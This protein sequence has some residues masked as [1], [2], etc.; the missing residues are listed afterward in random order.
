[1]PNSSDFRELRKRLNEIRKHFLPKKFSPTGAYTKREYDK[2]RGYCLLVHAEIEAYLEKI[3]KNIALLK[4]SDWKRNKKS[5]DLIICLLA[6]YHTGWATDEDGNDTL[7]AE[8]A[9]QS[10]RKVIRDSIS[11][12]V[13]AALRQYC[14]KV[15]ANNGIKEVNI[16]RLVLPIGVRVSELDQ[17]WV[18]NMDNF[19]KARGNLAHQSIGTQQPL[20]PMSTL[21]DVN[22]LLV[23]I[24]QLDEKIM[25]II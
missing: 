20:D 9:P 19:G 22:A 23:G 18:T 14:A 15:E 2:V 25:M 17:T 6:A 7:Y 16:K 4:V 13:D 11:E 12:S 1:M 24:K 8:P 21:T 3:A 5:S 10:S